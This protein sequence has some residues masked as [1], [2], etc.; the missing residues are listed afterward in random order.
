MQP[1]HPIRWPWIECYA[2]VLVEN[3]GLQETCFDSSN[4]N[5][6]PAGWVWP[7][8]SQFSTM[9]SSTAP[10]RPASWP[11]RLGR[12]LNDLLLTAFF[13][14]FRR[15]NRRTRHL[16]WGQLQGQHPHHAGWNML[17]L[18]MNLF[19]KEKLTTIM[20]WKSKPSGHYIFTRK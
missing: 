11:N 13:P 17:M 14:G 3:F 6:R 4:A 5:V 16:E 20:D 9:R 18:E 7:W 19:F 1:T 2:W 8:I 12:T 10:T 15:R